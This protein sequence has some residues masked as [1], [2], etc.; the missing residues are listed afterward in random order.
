MP[1]FS[2]VDIAGARG[3][4]GAVVVVDVL[5][6]FTTAAWAIQLGA[7]E[8]VLV[9]D[10]DEALAFK[11]AH[12]G[13]LAFC[14]GSAKEGFDLHNSPVQLLSLDVAGRRIAQRTGHGTQGVVAAAGAS[15]LLCASFVVAGATVRHLAGARAEHV[16]FVV[17]GGEE[18]QAC[19]EYIAG[20]LG[21]GPPDLSALA[22][23]RSSPA[24]IDLM[25]KGADDTYTGVDPADVDM[26]L[27]L[28]RFAF[29]L[30]VTD[31]DGRQ[32]LRG[33]SG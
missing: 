4:E 17:T 9:A 33:L 25:E 5:R 10:L 1:S 22:R 13:S 27:E 15:P 32:V 14:D 18:D 8:I 19:A 20:L 16:T 2:Y 28:D 26:C 6:A 23:A 29:T 30:E 11:A 3:V 31:I 7:T 21:G 12:P 24:A